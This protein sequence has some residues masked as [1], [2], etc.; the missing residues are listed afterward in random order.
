MPPGDVVRV[1]HLRGGDD[2]GDA[3]SERGLATRA[4]PIDGDHEGSPCVPVGSVN[5]CLD[6]VGDSLHPPWP[7]GGLLGMEPHAYA[8]RILAQW[9]HDCTHRMQ[10][11]QGWRSTE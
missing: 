10:R 3:P 2:V 8:A 4:A 9:S 5:K 7:G 6:D 11:L 1:H